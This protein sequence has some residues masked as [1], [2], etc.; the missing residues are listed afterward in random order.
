M[1]KLLIILIAMFSI[2]MVAKA[3]PGD[4]TWVGAN[5]V[6]LGGYGSYDS[7]IV[8]PHATTTT[9]RRIYMIFTLGK[10]MCGG[11]GYCGD[12]D[13]TVQ[14]YLIKPGGETFELGRLITPYAN[15]GAPRTPWTWTQHYV[16]DVTDYVAKFQDTC[17]IRIFYSGY[18]GGFTANI[19]FAFV[20]GIPDRNTL[21]IKRLWGGSFTYG[22]TTHHDSNDINLHFPAL[23]ETAPAGTQT[24]DLKFTVTGHGA[25]N[26]YCSEFCS[27][28][29]RVL[30]NGSAVATRTIWRNDCGK[31]EL[32][33][34]SGTWLYQRGNWCPGALVYSHHNTLTG[35]SGGTNFNT[36][37]VFDTYAGNGG[38]SYTT[39]GTLIY[40]GNMN[41][42]LDATLEDII[43]PTT[44]ENHYRENPACGK[45]TIH[46]KNTGATLITSMDISYNVQGYAPATFSWTGSLASLAE[47]DIVLPELH[48]L[49]TVSGGLTALTFYAAIT[50]VN[51]AADDDSTNNK[52]QSQF[53]PAPFFPTKFTIAFKTNNEPIATGSAISETSWILYDMNNNVMAS[54]VNVNISTLYNDT[55]VL[56]P[57]C[58]KLVLTDSSCNGLQWWANDTSIHPGSF[59][60]RRITGGNIQMHG[61]NY[62]GTY[63]NDFGCGYSAY[64]YTDWPAGVEEVNA[65]ALNIDAYPNPAQNAINVYIGGIANIDGTIKVIDALGRV[66][67]EQPCN[68]ALSQMNTTALT[69]GIYTIQYIENGN[70]AHKLQVRMVI[71]K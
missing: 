6:Q 42:T 59:Y 17:K 54:R 28:D 5:N 47:T 39:E 50:T 40:Y 61:Y 34:Q 32:S 57:G 9:Y 23:T 18:S 30:V 55:I 12:W 20:E 45:P 37:L 21:G 7:T 62:G 8:L 14:N 48:D 25:D 64:F 16:Y 4:T 33:P 52:R 70:N 36:Q 69:N 58:Y 63:G 51:G 49:N 29:Y 56:G 27:H 60:V 68:E 10:Y 53:I 31:N 35:V 24:A 43:A 13:Y 26:N 67:A 46:V 66:V 22:D 19:K 38:A 2:N 65:E 3:A 71:A 15:A 44:D 11:T 41:K 1:K